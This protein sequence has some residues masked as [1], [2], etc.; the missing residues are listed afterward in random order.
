MSAYESSRH[1]KAG[2]RDDKTVSR[3]EKNGIRAK[4]RLD[5]APVVLTAKKDMR[6]R[7]TKRALYEAMFNLLADEDFENITVNDIC[8]AASVSRTT[9]YVYFEDKYRLTNYCI[10]ELVSDISARSDKD[11]IHDILDKILAA[12]DENRRVF[13]NLLI[14]GNREL[15]KILH[16]E[17]VG[18]FVHLLSGHPVMGTASETQIGMRAVFLASGIS[19]LLV[20][21]ISGAFSVTKDEMTINLIQ[22]LKEIGLIS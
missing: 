2:N 7:R 9:F 14:D 19:N 16:L 5:G 15:E 6:S 13:Q 17:M 22:I 4:A 10:K 18:D 21:W 11:D 1:K 20:W 12:I 3:N 8:M